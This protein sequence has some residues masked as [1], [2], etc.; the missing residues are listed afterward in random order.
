MKLGMGNILDIV[1]SRAN[2]DHI[3]AVLKLLSYCFRFI[4]GAFLGQCLK[5]GCTQF[6]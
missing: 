3:M 2:N 5:L 4:S 6:M 1:I